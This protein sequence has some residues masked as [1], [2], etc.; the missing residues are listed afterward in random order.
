MKEALTPVAAEPARQQ[1]AQLPPD[2]RH[3]V[4]HDLGRRVVGDGRGFR[5]GND[6]VLLELGK[7]IGIVFWRPHQPAGGR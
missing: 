5:R 4:G 6:K 3:P 7:N 2:V 1:A